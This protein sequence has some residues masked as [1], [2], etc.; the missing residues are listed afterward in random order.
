MKNLKL[1]S[2]LVIAVIV[3]FTVGSIARGAEFSK[4]ITKA[5]DKKSDKTIIQNLTG[6]NNLHVEATGFAGYTGTSVTNDDYEKPTLAQGGGGITAGWWFN[7]LALDMDLLVGVTSDY[8]FIN[9][10]SDVTANVGNRRG[11]RWNIASLTLG[12]KLPI[13]QN[14]IIVKGD[15]QYF[16]DYVLENTTAQG[17]TLKYKKPMGG[18]LVG[19]YPIELPII[20][21]TYFGAHFE[22]LWFSNL[23]VTST[24]E[25][26]NDVELGSSLSVWDAGLNVSYMF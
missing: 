21:T 25:V 26:A 22:Y 14:K 13:L 8:R 18:R 20:G 6:L 17:A 5:P 9:Q 7:K 19:M 4:S 10:Y 1:A 24:A 3:V 2:A 12:T 16:G 11:H 15:F 23:E